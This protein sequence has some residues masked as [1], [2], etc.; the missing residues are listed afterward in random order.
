MKN[1]VLKA[2]RIA[3]AKSLANDVGNTYD[4]YVARMLFGN[5]GTAGGVPKYVDEGRNGLFGLTVLSK[6]IL[7]S[8]DPNQ[9]TQVIFTSVIAFNEVN[10]VAIN[11]MA[12]QMN[13]GQLYSMRTFPDLTKTDHIQVTWNWKLNFV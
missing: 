4:F 12:L 9:T 6:P 5:G 2:G 10:N 1:T 11:E 8:I 7:S 13:N 3:L